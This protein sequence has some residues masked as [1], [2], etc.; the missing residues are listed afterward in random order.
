M[1]GGHPAGERHLH[2][3]E[4]LIIAALVTAL[5]VAELRRIARWQNR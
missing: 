5:P 2:L 3:I 4:A 1:Q